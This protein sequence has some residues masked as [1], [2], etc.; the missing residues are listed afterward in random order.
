MQ[1][2]LTEEKLQKKEAEL[3]KEIEASFVNGTWR[4][5]LPGREILKHFV[6]AQ[7]VPTNYEVFRNQIV[8]RMAAAGIKPEG[9]R[10]IIASIVKE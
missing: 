4:S 9:M 7:Q 3:R 2:T 5:K 8:T 1:D 6:N 10:K